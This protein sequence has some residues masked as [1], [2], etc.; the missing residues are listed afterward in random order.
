MRSAAPRRD[1][2]QERTDK[3]VKYETNDN[4]PGAKHFMYT[5]RLKEL[6]FLFFD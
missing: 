5:E 3:K 2:T 6:A 1:D 4:D